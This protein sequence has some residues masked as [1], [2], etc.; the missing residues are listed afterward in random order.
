MPS[1]EFD[2]IYLN[3]TQI[4]AIGDLDLNDYSQ[5]VTYLIRDRD[6]DGKV[7]TDRTGEQIRQEEKI[8]YMVLDKA[9]DMFLIGAYTGL[10]FGNFSNL[11]LKSV[12]H[13]FIKLKQIKTGSR[14][15]IPIMKSCARS[16][17][18]AL[19]SYLPYQTKNLTVILTYSRVCGID[20]AH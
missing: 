2:T 9:R 4:E 8:G 5:Y 10:R 15:S 16:Y 17:Q 1:Y 7:K 18:N 14:I 13:N 12:E 19:M 11:D 3:Q 6:R 20:R